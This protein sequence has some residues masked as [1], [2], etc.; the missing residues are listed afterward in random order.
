MSFRRLPTARSCGRS[1]APL[2]LSNSCTRAEPAARACT[3]QAQAARSPGRSCCR[4]HGPRPCRVGLPGSSAPRQTTRSPSHASRWSCEVSAWHGLE[5]VDQTE[6]A[7]FDRAG[8]A[9]RN[10]CLALGDRRKLRHHPP[11]RAPAE[12]VERDGG[13]TGRRA[14]L[15]HAVIDMAPDQTVRRL[16][17]EE[18]KIHIH[19]LPLPKPHPPL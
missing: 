7:G 15:A 5:I 1:I 14:L 13:A 2:R 16:A 19:F 3:Y 11:A 17:F 8:E 6:V 4:G 9:D 10:P 18:D 12:V